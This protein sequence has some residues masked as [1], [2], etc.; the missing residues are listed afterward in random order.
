MVE[1]RSTALDRMGEPARCQHVR[2]TWPR[3]RRAGGALPRL[4]RSD[5]TLVRVPAAPAR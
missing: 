5:R 4:R 2:G 1:T 3:D